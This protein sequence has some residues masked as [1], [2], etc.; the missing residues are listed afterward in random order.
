MEANQKTNSLFDSLGIT[1][2]ETKVLV[3]KVSVVKVTAN[4]AAA[5]SH[6][7]YCVITSADY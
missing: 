7:A 4:S 3:A 1:A 6:N 2:K 5:V